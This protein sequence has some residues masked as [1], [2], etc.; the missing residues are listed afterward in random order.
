MDDLRQV[1]GFFEHAAHKHRGNDEEFREYLLFDLGS[2]EDVG[3]LRRMYAPGSF[4][5]KFMLLADAKGNGYVRVQKG[6]KSHKD[7][8]YRM[9]REGIDVSAMFNLKGGGDVSAIREQGKSR[10][11]FHGASDDFG[12]F[13]RELLRQTLEQHLDKDLPY[14]IR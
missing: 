14:D 11:I 6:G 7:I 10:F 3:T 1:D 2:S 4:G 8:L 5:I 13:D 12:K 9:E